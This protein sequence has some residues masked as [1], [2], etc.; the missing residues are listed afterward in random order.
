MRSQRRSQN[1]DRG[2]TLVE[3]ALI[4]PVFVLVMLG[5]L[6]L[7]RAVFA[8]HT[9]NNSAR[10]AVR[11]AI[12]NQNTTV[13]TDEAISQGVGLGLTASDV[14]ITFLDGSYGDTAPCNIAPRFGC[15]AEIE[16]SYDYT[17]VTPIIGSLVGTIEM[18]GST[19]QPIERTYQSTP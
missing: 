6:D 1:R 3:F 12:V 18:A 4:L 13:I 8:Y 9:I 10:E 17:A 7:G 14:D 11:V 5:V 15:V 16:V 19:R 2:Q